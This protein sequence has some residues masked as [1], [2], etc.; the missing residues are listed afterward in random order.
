M[1]MLSYS[2]K[3]RDFFI[4]LQISKESNM[5][6]AKVLTNKWVLSENTTI[7]YHIPIHGTLRLETQPRH[8]HDSKK[9]IKIKHS[10]RSLF[11]PKIIEKL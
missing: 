11:L 4:N 9:L 8:Q 7:T 6:S 10:T 5:N 3:C 2:V 1:K